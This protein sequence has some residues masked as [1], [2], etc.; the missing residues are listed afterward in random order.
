LGRAEGVDLNALKIYGYLD[1]V[2]TKSNNEQGNKNGSFDLA[3]FNLLFDFPV[4]SKLIVKTHIIF[5]GAPDTA[6]DFGTIKVEWNFFEYAFRDEFKFRGGQVVTPFGI[7]NEVRETAPAFLTVEVPQNLILPATRGGFSFF[8]E[9]NKGGGI[10]GRFFGSGREGSG[11]EASY[12][13]YVGNG[14]NL[15][16]VNPAQ[17]DDNADKSVGGRFNYSPTD[18]LF[19]GLSFFTG[20]RAVTDTTDSRHN[21]LGGHFVWNTRALNIS[22]E[23]AYS[24]FNGQEEWGGF[25]QTSYRI[26]KNLALYYRY[27][28]LDPNINEFKDTWETHLFGLNWNPITGMYMKVEF[29]FHERGKDNSLVTLGQTDFSEIQAAIAVAF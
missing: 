9:H 14:E 28:Y 4:T 26:L 3:H 24:E 25:T 2:Y 15:D 23:G 11:W 18:S 7:F 22:V 5:Q 27:E 21:S 16:T 6:R 12:D 17:F 8:P 19:F 10:L 29:N 13:L 1:E 20:E